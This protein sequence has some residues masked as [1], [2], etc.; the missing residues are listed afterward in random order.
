MTAPKVS[1]L[2]PNYNY[3]RFLP[4]AISSVFQQQFTDF[5]LLVSDNAST[6]DSAAVIRRLAKHDSR[7]QFT[8]QPVNLGMV[9]NFNWCLSHARGE[10][11]KFL[12]ADDKLAGPQALSQLVC[13]LEA[14]PSASLAASARL[15]IGEDSAVLGTW[16]HFAG[17]GLHP[18]TEVIMRCL[19]EARNLIGEPS[20]VLFRRRDAARGFSVRYR[21]I[22]DEE[23]WLHLL[24]KGDFV[25]TSVP[26]C[27]FRRHSRQQSETHEAGQIGHLESMLL[28]QEHCPK[29]FLHSKG[30]AKRI[31]ERV[32]E[33]RKWRKRNPQLSGELLAIEQK[34]ATQISRS[35]YAIH[36][37]ERRLTQPF[38]NLKRWMVRRRHRTEPAFE[39]DGSNAP[40]RGYGPSGTNAPSG[41]P[42]ANP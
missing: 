16:D 17:S 23:M 39:L 7:L 36:W 42:G 28:F 22:V 14:N 40:L 20:A 4:E 12:L 37:L 5:E 2:V 13:L 1:V 32:Y 35:S 21:Q 3:A 25:Y 15:V 6:D 34:L 41:D 38:R 33:I 27:C 8:L 24:E 30:S 31:F 18:G 29:S 19:L 26:L 9:G 11:I 10:Y